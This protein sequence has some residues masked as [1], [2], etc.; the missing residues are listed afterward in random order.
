MR[1]RHVSIRNF[2]GIKECN[3]HIPARLVCLVGPGG[4]TKTT[5]LDALGLA[6][7]RSYRAQFT[8][9]DFYG[10]DTDKAIRIEVA[11]TEL[12]DD[13]IQ[14]KALGLDRSGIWP[15]GRLEHDPIEGTEECLLIRL[16][17]DR[18]LEPTWQVVRPGDDEGRSVTATQRQKLAFFRVGEYVD[19]QLRWSQASALS[20]LTEGGTDAT[21]VV[22][23]AHRQARAAAF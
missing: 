11:V 6:L 13:L 2:R 23:D 14:E 21:A 18:A 17:V 8:D 7:S 10:C 15:D 20:A 1:I 3:W 19:R 12:P 9:A 4:S 5:L 16:E 22:V